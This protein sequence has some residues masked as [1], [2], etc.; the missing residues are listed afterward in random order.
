MK[1]KQFFSIVVG[2]AVLIVDQVTKHLSLAQEQAVLNSGISFGLFQSFAGML[3]IYVLLIAVVFWFFWFRQ[4]QYFVAANMAFAATSNLLDR[5]RYG[6]V[7]DW[8]PI[9]GTGLLN[10]LAD[11]IISLCLVVYVLQVVRQSWLQK[12]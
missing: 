3:G 6:A 1:R 10:N 4:K 8:L 7:I 9:P 11:W 12:Q 5:F 2:S